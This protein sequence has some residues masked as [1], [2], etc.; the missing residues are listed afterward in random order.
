M[1]G[2]AIAFGA[3]VLFGS[4]M[5]EL[6]QSET[7]TVQVANVDSLA[8]NMLIYSNYVNM[9]ASANAGTQGTISETALGLPSWFAKRPELTNVVSSGRGFVYA[10]A[11]PSG[12]LGALSSKAGQS[13]MVGSR[14]GANLLSPDF[15]TVT[16]IALPGEIPNGAVVVTNATF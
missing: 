1:W 16:A 14:Q 13:V 4:I 9:Y 2:I 11:T 12:L 15:G 10:Q 7:Q 3:T 5:Y 8:A 6:N